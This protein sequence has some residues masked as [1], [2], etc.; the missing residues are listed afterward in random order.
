MIR[1]LL[2]GAAA[3][4]LVVVLLGAIAFG[5]LFA[6]YRH[7]VNQTP[8]ALDV[9]HTPGRL[10]AEVNV[11]NATGGIPYLASYNSP[12]ATVPWGRARLAPDTASILFAVDSLAASGYWYGDNRILGFSHMRLLGADAEDGG[13]FRV[14]PVPERWAARVWDG[15]RTLRFT[16][17]DE[18]GAPGYYAV[19]LLRDDTLCELTATTRGGIHRYTFAPGAPPVLMIDVTSTIGTART[20]DA[21]VSWD[22]PNASIDARVRTFGTFAGRYGG[23]PCFLHARTQP[24]FTR[25]ERLTGEDGR[26]GVALYFDPAEDGPTEVLLRVGLSNVDADNARANFEAEVAGRAFDDVARAAREEWERMLARIEVEGGTADQR[27]IFYTALYRALQ[28]PSRWDDVNGE[29]RFEDEVRNAE[30]F[31]FYSDFSLWDTFRTVHPLYNL[32]ARDTQTHM[33]RAML[34]M[35]DIGGTLPRWAAAAGYAGSMIGSPADMTFAEAW[36]KGVRG[37]DIDAAYR[38]MVRGATPD[39]GPS[40]RRQTAAFVEYGY[41]PDDVASKSVGLTLEYA[42]ADTSIGLLAEAQGQAED[43]NRFLARG[44]AYANLF[45]PATQFFQPRTTA[46][47]WR[48]IDPLQLTYTDFDGERTRAYVEGSAMQWR[49]GVPYDPEG[50]VAQFKSAEYFATE[51]N[52]YF[53]GA[54]ETV[55][56]WHPGGNYWHGNEPYFHA[57]YLFN[58]AGRPDLT[59]RWVHWCLTTRYADNHIG[60]DGNDDGGT[61]SAWYVFSALGFYPIAGTARYEIGTPLFARTALDMGAGK[62]L[63]IVAD[64]HTPG[65]YLVERVE[66]N[67]EP[68]DQWHFM[69]DRIA[70]GGTLRFVMQAE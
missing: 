55:G 32:I 42:W 35:A 50:L 28:M 33:L 66:I 44:K 70:E 37:Y 52:A 7:V 8:G 24:P 27:R 23:L 17:R 46:G 59:Q 20:E 5:T 49:W 54:T 62:T 53:E 29:Y 18:Y 19:R 34:A 51:L 21:A 63:E 43:A 69:H 65:N 4:L 39:A 41:V 31:A 14:I 67:G 1:R 58:A 9:A 47:A 68:L 64:N 48:E 60:L 57:P 26:L 15:T 12:A 2:A 16:H 38:Y 22:A 10:G 40:K 3:L 36:L 61:I 56:E 45:N 25:A 13:Q 6:T 11:F 30:D